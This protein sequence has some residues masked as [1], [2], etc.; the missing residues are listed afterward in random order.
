VTAAVRIDDPSQPCT[1]WLCPLDAV[2]SPHELAWLAADEHA[3]AARFMM[4]H[5]RRRF[6]AARCA[7]RERLSQQLR[8]PPESLRFDAGEH[9]K[10]YLPDAPQC[11]FNL[12][13]SEDWALVGIGLHGETGVDIEVLRDVDDALPLARTLFTAEELAQFL[14]LDAIAQR[15]AFLRVWTRKEA[16]MK[17]L[18]L[19]LSLA[20]RTIDVGLGPEAAHLQVRLHD[21]V[22]WVTVR[23]I[24]VSRHEALAAVAWI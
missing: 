18:G 2:P 21:G 8:V 24:D 1:L 6:L 13:H 10:P 3:R 11:H 22:V 16:V 9:G 7:L 23:S 17:A 19:G 4:H 12:S 14:A 5:H 20:P 15:T